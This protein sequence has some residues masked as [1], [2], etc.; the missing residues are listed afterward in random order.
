MATEKPKSQ[1][2]GKFAEAMRKSKE[3]RAGMQQQSEQQAQ[4][5]EESIQREEANRQDRDFSNTKDSEI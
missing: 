5:K 1:T 2:E 3:K 4:A